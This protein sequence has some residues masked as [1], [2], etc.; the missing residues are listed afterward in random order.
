MQ[1]I[2]ARPTAAPGPGSFAPISHGVRMLMEPGAEL[3]FTQPSGSQ[4]TGQDIE[5]VF[6]SGH[7]PSVQIEEEE[8]DHE[9]DALVAIG[10]WMVGYE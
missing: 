8:H 3:I 1:L 7:L 6:R 10:K 4:V 9:G 5:F 2:R